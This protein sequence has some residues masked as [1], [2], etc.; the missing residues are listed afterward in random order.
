MNKKSIPLFNIYP[1]SM[2]E[3]QDRPCDAKFS[4]QTN[5]KVKTD[6]WPI[7]PLPLNSI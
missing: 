2:G 3:G 7:L 6:T 5:K 1:N 4:E